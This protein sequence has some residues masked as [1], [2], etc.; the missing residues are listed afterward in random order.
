VSDLLACPNCGATTLWSNE[1]ATVGYPATF[2]TD[3]TGPDYTGGASE[4]YDDAT[5]FED[6]IDCRSCG[7][8][9]MNMSELV[10]AEEVSSD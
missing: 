9:G 3:G 10:G 2:G 8:Y 6:D 4:I 1:K 7:T 5:A